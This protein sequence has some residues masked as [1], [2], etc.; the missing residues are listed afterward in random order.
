MRKSIKGL[1]NSLGDT[2]FRFKAYK[3]GCLIR[4]SHI[5][6]S[7]VGR[8]LACGKLASWY[9]VTLTRT[10]SELRLIET[11]YERN[12]RIRNEAKEYGL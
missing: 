6:Q 7:Q 3:L 11:T 12:S 8:C 5:G 4:G 2:A 1:R 9:Q 10:P